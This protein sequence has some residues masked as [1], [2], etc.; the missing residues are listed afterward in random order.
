MKILI[1]NSSK[2]LDVVL[3]PFMGIGSTGIACKQLNR[4]FIGCE[5]D[6]KFYD[7]ANRRFN[8]ENLIDTNDISLFD[9]I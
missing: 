8:E 4:S 6:K 9:I 5:I 3:D 7:I 1:A 2:E